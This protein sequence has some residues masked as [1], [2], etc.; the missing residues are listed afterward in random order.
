MLV[1]AMGVALWLTVLRPSAPAQEY[2]RANPPVALPAAYYKSTLIHGQSLL[3]PECP[4]T[5]RYTY[6]M[7]LSDQVTRGRLHSYH[8]VKWRT[9]MK[10]HERESRR[11][12]CNWLSSMSS[13]AP[14]PLRRHR[15][16]GLRLQESLQRRQLRRATVFHPRGRL[17]QLPCDAPPHEG[18]R[19][20]PSPAGQSRPVGVAP[21]R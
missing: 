7:K 20:I 15:R 13:S 19:G 10:A 17:S 1:G 6:G 11:G 9:D 21:P 2:Q 16:G 12:R 18:P 3:I 4:C 8:Q 14:T 5:V